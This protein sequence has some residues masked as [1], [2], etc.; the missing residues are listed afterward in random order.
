MDE[1]TVSGKTLVAEVTPEY[2][3]FF[4]IAPE[5]L[6]FASVSIEDLTSLRGGDAEK[7]G[8]IISEVLENKRLDAARSLVLMNAAAAIFVGGKAANLLEAVELAAASLESGRA[9][10]KL[11]SLVEKTREET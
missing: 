6:G 9:L 8:V 7:N 10:A 11:E 5:D 4:E 1:I 2:L 3:K